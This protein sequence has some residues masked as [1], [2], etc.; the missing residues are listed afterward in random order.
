VS[1]EYASIEEQLLERLPELR[2]AVE[3]YWKTEGSPGQDPGP[4]ILFEGL[5][6]P[7][8]TTLLV[9]P[10]T[11]KRDAL[12]RRAFDVADDLLS[13]SPELH[14]LGGIA[15]FEGQ[16]SEWFRLARPF[17]GPRARSEAERFGWEVKSDAKI[18]HSNDS[19]GVRL[20]IRDLL[21][22]SGAPFGAA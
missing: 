5:F 19:Y 10:A 20:L 16:T 4:Y 14:D 22:S 8:I 6:R 2:P 1:L 12:L 7:Y 15:V 17:L 9:A 21:A 3:S 11:P 13:A 18:E